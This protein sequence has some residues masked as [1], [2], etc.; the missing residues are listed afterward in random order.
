VDTNNEPSN[1]AD[2]TKDNN[3]IIERYKYILSQI[4]TI[5]ENVSKYLTLFQTLTTAIVG[6][7]I[8]VFLN[9]KK[10]DV[11][12]ELA[13]AAINGLTILLW[14]L[15]A[16]VFISITVGILSWIDYRNEEVDLLEK[17][18]TPELRQ[19]PKLINFWRWYETYILVFTVVSTSVITFF[20]ET[21]IIPLIK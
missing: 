16:F 12:P 4:H 11:A 6:G 14:L 7:G 19:R 17:T 21:Q 5:N 20:V 10:M 13:V 15:T 8:T 9:W 18:N 2:T 3:Y 1:N